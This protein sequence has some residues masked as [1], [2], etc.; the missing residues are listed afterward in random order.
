MYSNPTQNLTCFLTDKDGNRLDP[1]KPNSITYT[2]IPN[3]KD[4]RRKVRFPSVENG[5]QSNITVLLQGYI[6]VAIDGNIISSPIP[7]N[8]SSDLYLKV[9]KGTSLDLKVANFQCSTIGLYPVKSKKLEHLRINISIC[10]VVNVIGF[11]DL[12][13]P[14]IQ[15]EP[16]KSFDSSSFE[17]ERTCVTVMKVFSSCTFKNKITI[18]CKKSIIQADLYQYNALW[19]GCNKIYTN[20]DELT[21]YGNK[22]ILDPKD[23]SYI[24]VFINGVLQPKIN[25]IVNKGV[26]IVKTEDCSVA[27]A[28]IA[29]VFFT[30][31]DKFGNVLKGQN[32]QYNAVSDGTKRIYTNEDEITLYGTNG[33][34][35]PST[36]TYFNLFVNGVLQP[37]TT[38]EVKEGT[39]KFLTVDI[40]PKDVPIILQS[41]R[42]FDTDNRLFKGSNYQYNTLGANKKIYTNSDELLMYG[43]K[44]ILN[45]SHVSYDNLYINGVIQ[46]KVN[47]VVC[48][49][50]LKLKT[51]DTPIEGAPISLQ[52]VTVSNTNQIKN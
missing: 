13:I 5:D 43:D 17:F 46:P 9:P 51:A 16:P 1:Y 14:A 30:F 39:L 23:V 15:W 20:Q 3:I 27:G 47:Y 29:V 35:A 34:P 38:Y 32:P 33:I 11:V 2:I 12:I 4:V 21:Q 8:A 42:I 49:D 28:P 25:Y 41:I 22:G 18:V 10:T 26:L 31:K 40:P 7:F 50:V 37:S 52:F 36:V 48:K 24:N 6:S 45:P 19:K 44:G